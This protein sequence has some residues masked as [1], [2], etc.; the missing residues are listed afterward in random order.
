MTEGVSR[1]KKESKKRKILIVYLSRALLLPIIF[2]I[3]TWPFAIDH[4]REAR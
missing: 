1:K 3:F 2:F 4:W